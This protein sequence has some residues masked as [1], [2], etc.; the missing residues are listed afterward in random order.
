MV[1][2]PN[3]QLEETFMA[4]PY[5]G[6]APPLT[7]LYFFASLIR[8]SAKRLWKFRKFMNQVPSSK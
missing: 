7:H 6:E 1:Y 8:R 4:F 2:L 3:Q 5:L